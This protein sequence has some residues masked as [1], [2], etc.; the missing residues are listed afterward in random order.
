MARLGR[1]PNKYDIR[2][3]DRFYAYC[4]AVS[5]T[6]AHREEAARSQR[7]T[8]RNIWTMLITGGFLCY[9]LVERVAQAMALY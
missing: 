5:S 2:V 3:V 8:R 4:H 9:Y 6:N 7:A 1:K